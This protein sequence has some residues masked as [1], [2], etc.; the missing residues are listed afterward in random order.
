MCN[1][2][3]IFHRAG[4]Y[5]RPGL[6]TVTKITDNFSVHN[7]LYFATKYVNRRPVCWQECGK[8]YFN[9]EISTGPFV[10][11]AAAQYTGSSKKMDGI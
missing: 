10:T 9:A 6:D 5:R 4:P 7:A 3:C 2:C 8:N 11:F 1:I